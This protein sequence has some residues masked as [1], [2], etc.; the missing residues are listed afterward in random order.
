M[1]PLSLLAQGLLLAHIFMASSF[2]L[3]SIIFPWCRE[4][5]RDLR[6]PRMMMRIV[7]TCGL[8]IAAIGFLGFFLAVAHW[9]DPIGLISGYVGLCAAAC[10]ARRESPFR[11]AFWVARIRAVMGAFDFSSLI[12]YYAMLALA[13]P[14]ILP[15][16]GGSDPIGFHLV[17][18]A[19]LLRYD[20]FAVDPFR[21]TPFYVGDFIPIF[22]SFMAF[23]AD[24]FVNF[25]TWSTGLL[26]AL[27]VCA[28]CKDAMRDS[29]REPWQSLI[30]IALTATVVAN[31]VYLRWGATAYMDVQIGC[32]ALLS[33][34]SILLAVQER[35]AT[36]IYVAI[37]TSGF[38]IGMKPSFAVLLPVYAIAFVFAVRKVPTLKGNWLIVLLAFVAAS[39]PWYV[40]NLILAGDPIPPVFNIALYGRD[41]LMTKFEWSQITTDIRTPKTFEAL[42][43]LPI[44]AYLSPQGRD[45]RENGTSALFLA[46]YVP[47]ALCLLLMLARGRVE[48]S[49]FLLA[50]FLTLFELYWF[51]SST[52]LRYALVFTPLLALS[53]GY[54]FSMMASFIPRWRYLTGPALTLLAFIAVIPSPGSSVFYSAWRDTYDGLPSYQGFD[55]YATIFG[56]GDPEA[57]FTI[58][59]IQRARVDSRVY[60][61]G[62]GVAYYFS[63]AG[64]TSMGDW[65]G[66]AGWFRLYSSLNTG[67]LGQYLRALGVGVVL[68]DPPRVL[69]GLDVP[70]SRALGDA[71]F[72]SVSIPNSSWQLYVN[73]PNICSE[74]RAQRK[75]PGLLRN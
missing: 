37:V 18:A 7:C 25:L 2:L 29:V 17:N 4:E 21:R 59:M 8:G 47:A 10:A 32:F 43:S 51:A 26:T 11:A 31:P 67:Q 53:G 60:V 63:R 61:L 5:V 48:T 49:L 68:I 15:N 38:F 27:G 24:A 9:F 54:L 23:G 74:E 58:R 19:D 22:S 41:G 65:V 40:R 62:P 13:F 66:P 28:A 72:C 44:R 42:A 55:K 39:S 69:G 14:A 20:G 30:A 71:Q 36:W 56:N 1:L 3:G 57:L 46:L 16:I 34:L 35:R 50:W 73:D 12:V 70:L 33:V 52:L 75:T 45:F 64:I 6:P